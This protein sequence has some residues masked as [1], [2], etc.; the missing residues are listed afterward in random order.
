MQNL[1]RHFLLVCLLFNIKSAAQ[2]KQ[3][4]LQ[5]IKLPA[6]LND[7]DN[8]FSCLNI[9]DGRLY[10]MTESRI[11]ESQEAKI[12]SIKLAD[13]DHHME[14]TSFQLPYQK[15][16]I[17]G[18]DKLVK[19]MILQ[20]QLCEGLEAMVM[21]GN[22]VYF[23][24]ETTTESPYCYLLKGKF[25]DENIYLDS[26]QLLPV[27]K[28]VKL[29]G[30]QIFNASFESMEIKKKHLLL[31]FEYNYFTVSNWV[32][33]YNKNFNPATKDSLKIDKMPY[34]ISDIKRIRRN[35]YS[36]I[37]IFYKGDGR[38]T[39][40]RPSVTDTL[41][42][43]LVANGN[44]FHNYARIIGVFCNGKKFE[45]KPVLEIPPVYEGFNW[46]AIAY[47]KHGYFI[48][49]D[50]YTATKPYYSALLFLRPVK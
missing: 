28:P 21:K 46:E 10:L 20:G 30:E 27:L 19:R 15:H 31:F 33:S 45:W 44:S 50:K 37:N 38:D 3:F 48:V 25:K 49:N 35:Q 12:Y 42:Y 6:E 8:Q 16:L 23:S 18:F 43:S 13:L 32:Y 34:R 4:I 40:Y 24:V 7:F 9:Q 1:I 11:P 29:N 36:A 39:I 26:T 5:T 2:D 17:I 41:N 14:D 47:Y 22:Q